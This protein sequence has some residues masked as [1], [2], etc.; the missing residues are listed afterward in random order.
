MKN[1]ER[2]G[3]IIRRM[4]Q[5]NVFSRFSFAFLILFS[6]FCSTKVSAQ[7]NVDRLIMSGRVAVYYEDYILGIQYFNQVIAMKPYLYEPWQMRAIAKFHLDD[8]HGAEA[9]VSEAIKL[10]PYVTLLYD[11]RGISRIRI[12]NYEGA[13]ADYNKALS[14]DPTNQ[15]FWYNRAACRVETKDYERA[16]LEL[17]TIITKWKKYASPYLLK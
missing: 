14:L 11:L 10:N 7:Y 17:D 15:N 9:D 5:S 4:M 1:K 13:I 6:F 16:H 2:M 3:I 12:G 8:Y